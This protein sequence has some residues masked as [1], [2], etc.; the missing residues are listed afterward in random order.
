MHDA[1]PTPDDGL[2]PS[3]HD[4]AAPVC[5]YTGAKNDTTQQSGQTPDKEGEIKQITCWL[6]KERPT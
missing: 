2:A 5:G 6:S 3:A 1:P 4:Y